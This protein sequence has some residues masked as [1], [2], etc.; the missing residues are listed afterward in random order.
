[1]IK[2]KILREQTFQSKLNMGIYLSY[3]EPHE[4]I[5]KIFYSSKLPR[6]QGLAEK[7]MNQI[8]TTK[9]LIWNHMKT[10]YSKHE[11]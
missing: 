5:L 7:L 4:M 3:E 2:Y 8:A 10:A 6:N 1:M 11:Y 9:G